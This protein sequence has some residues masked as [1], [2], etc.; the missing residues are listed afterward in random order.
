MEDRTCRADKLSALQGLFSDRGKADM[1][2][3]GE[4]GSIYREILEYHE[5][6][7]I[8]FVVKQPD[9]GGTAHYAFFIRVKSPINCDTYHALWVQLAESGNDFANTL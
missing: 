3:D 2:P 8:L 7:V 1:T 6:Y 5:K 9:L 4:R